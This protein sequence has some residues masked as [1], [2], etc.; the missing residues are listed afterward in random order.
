MEITTPTHDNVGAFAPEEQSTPPT[1][2][3]GE[4]FKKWLLET[5]KKYEKMNEID[6][7]RAKKTMLKSR[8]YFAGQQYGTVNNDLAWMDFEK[9]AGEV[10]YP[11]NV[12][13]AHIQTSLMELSRGETRLNF[14][15][16]AEESRLGELVCKLAEARYKVH[17]QRQFP[18]NKMTQE[19]LSLLLN[20]IAIRY[21]YVKWEE[22]KRGEKIPIFKDM[23]MDGEAQFKVCSV[24][25]APA[26]ETP[27]HELMESPEY[28]KTEH[29][30]G[31]NEDMC[32]NCGSTTFTLLSSPSY[33]GKVISGY[34]N[35]KCAESQWI[36]VD[37]MGCWF[38]LHATSLQ[39]SPYFIWKQAI[40]TDVLQA[41][42][43]DLKI[44]AGI[45][46]RELKESVNQSASTA[47]QAMG[48]SEKSDKSLSEFEQGWFEPALYK[49]YTL[50]ADVKLRSGAVIPAGTKLGDVF[51]DGLYIAKSGDKILDLWNEDKNTK[52]T[53]A[54]WVTQLGTLLGLGTSMLHDQQDRLNDLSNLIMQSAMNDS[55]SKEFVNAQYIDPTNIPTDPT[56][57]AVVT[58][59]PDG[60][61]IV[62][63]VIDRMPPASLTSDAYALPEAIQMTMQ[64]QAGTFSATGSGMPDLKAAQN[65]YSGMQLYR[66]ITVGRFY[67]MLSVRADE[68][69]AKQAYQF[70]ENDKKYLTPK[71]WEK[72]AGDYGAEAVRAFLACDLKK[73]LLITVV[74]ESFMPS[75]PAQKLMKTQGYLEI[76]GVAAPLMNKEM[77]AYLAAQYDIPESLIGFDAGYSIGVAHIETF[78]EICDMITEA[79]GD[80]PTSSL[81]D[82]IALQM[83]QLVLQTANIPVVPELDNLDAITEAYTDWW[84]K[85]QGRAASNLLRA[86]IAL[87]MMEIK[88]GIAMSAAGDAELAMMAQQPMQDAQ[89]EQEAQ[90]QAM[91][92]QGDPN[93]EAQMQ[94]EQ[95]ENE[96]SRA[97]EAE[98]KQ[99]D[100]E[101]AQKQ[102][103]HEMTMT[104]KEQKHEK[105][106]KKME[107]KKKPA[108]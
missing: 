83:G 50:K 88:Q 75:T 61:K 103:D 78:Q 11:E 43:P 15:Y 100:A 39:D 44:E 28:E 70:L 96:S 33:S 93:A 90:R 48:F 32:Q 97:H 18:P 107:A 104:E 47:I 106:I 63:S 37:P 59:L 101:E 77:N 10:V 81:Q 51:P 72:F 17:R 71:E 22:N 105:E 87:R 69:D 76:L 102:R 5:W 66:D 2:E 7:L 20:G 13:V 74:P 60:A 14:T 89:M 57:R 108:K 95:Q 1:F 68:L 42:Y 67:P 55:F 65:T 53:A 49:N 40:V 45:Q 26:E 64:M 25:G 73:D 41:Q 56:E 4:D 86:T 92:G 29:G 85:D 79:Q 54:A 82:P 35:Q 99:F 80:I 52:F 9:R 19:N 16:A 58:N 8:K 31:E 12:Y 27:Q 98:Q 91:E 36:V 94:A 21:T 62:G 46:S 38:D 23:K 84:Q 3:V 30:M 6:W 34:E 24:C